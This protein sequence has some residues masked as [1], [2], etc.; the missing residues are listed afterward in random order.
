[1]SA[2]IIFFSIHTFF[3]LFFYQIQAGISATMHAHAK[4]FV[5]NI[6]RVPLYCSFARPDVTTNKSTIFDFFWFPT[7]AK[8]NVYNST[9]QNKINVDAIAHDLPPSFIANKS[10]REF[11]QEDWSSYIHYEQKVTGIESKQIEHLRFFDLYQYPGYREFVKTLPGY[12]QFIIEVDERQKIDNEFRKQL[13]HTFGWK[14]GEFT[15]YMQDEAEIARNTIAKEKQREA[16]ELQQ[17]QNEVANNEKAL[18]TERYAEYRH[19]KEEFSKHV[20]APE[21]KTQSIAEFGQHYFKSMANTA[22]ELNDKKA[23]IHYENRVQELKKIEL[24]KANKLFTLNEHAQKLVQDSKFDTQFLTI[25]KDGLEQ[26]VHSEIAN[27]INGIGT[28]FNKTCIEENRLK[29]IHLLSPTNRNRIDKIKELYNNAITLNKVALDLQQQGDS[30]G[31][32]LALDT[33]ADMTSLANSLL[34]D[35]NMTD[36]SFKNM[37]SK[38]ILWARF[39]KNTSKSNNK[40]N[41]VFWANN[42]SIGLAELALREKNTQAFLIRNKALFQSLGAIGNNAQAI[43]ELNKQCTKRTLITAIHLARLKPNVIY[44]NAGLLEGLEQAVTH[45]NYLRPYLIELQKQGIDLLNMSE[46]GNILLPKPTITKATTSFEY[47]GVTITLD[48]YGN[49]HTEDGRVRLSALGRKQLGWISDEALKDEGFQVNQLPKE[50][51]TG[52]RIIQT[53]DASIAE[54][55]RQH[56]QSLINKANQQHPVAQKTM[57]SNDVAKP[58]SHNEQFAQNQVEQLLQQRLAAV[59]ETIN[60]P[61]VL[62]TRTY[63]LTPVAQSF[64]QQHSCNL[65]SY[66]SFT[67]NPMQHQTHSEVI[68]VLNQNATADLLCSEL[69]HNGLTLSVLQYCQVAHALNQENKP[70]VALSFLDFCRVALSNALPID[71]ANQTLKDAI[72]IGRGLVRSGENALEMCRHPLETGK[73]IVK[74]FLI[75]MRHMPD[76]YGPDIPLIPAEN[77]P[78]IKQAEESTKFWKTLTDHIN[79]RMQNST[80]EERLEFVGEL[81]GDVITQH[82]A[83]KALGK[84]PQIATIVNQALAKPSKTLSNFGPMGK[85]LAR[86]LGTTL[87]HGPVKVEA[88]FNLLQEY[89][90]L[91]TAEGVRLQ[92]VDRGIECANNIQKFAQEA[93]EKSIQLLEHPELATQITKHQL[94][95]HYIPKPANIIPTV[96]VEGK[97]IYLDYTNSRWYQ[98]PNGKWYIEL[99]EELYQKIGWA[100]ENRQVLEATKFSTALENAAIVAQIQPG[101]V[102]KKLSQIAHTFTPAQQRFLA[103][104]EQEIDALVQKYAG[105]KIMVPGI[106]VPIEITRETI[107]HVL[108]A[109]I[110]SKVKKGYHLNLNGLHHNLSRW[111]QNGVIQ[112]SNKK[113]LPN[114]VTITGIEYRGVTLKDLTTAFPDIWSNEQ[115]FDKLIEACGNITQVPQIQSKGNWIFRGKTIEG[116]PFE[117]IVEKNGYIKTFYPPFKI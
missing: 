30:F 49:A 117:I 26:V 27:S 111:E 65:A 108:G 45:I 23:G 101:N 28:L 52:Y 98:A 40:F 66:E 44:R 1:M 62:T 105:K 56:Q 110:I 109:E 87:E 83:L 84:A 53:T 112:F 41:Q 113:T 16:R 86:M 46:D 102:T 50:V 72:A 100:F 67:G 68:Q 39:K 88:A 78:S 81:L 33:A 34:H 42:I 74:T 61:H 63:Q 43:V 114:G 21:A 8:V 104:V 48:K 55:I 89:P 15:R 18:I 20:I 91:V 4:Q 94:P 10:F 79:E 69:K 64:L 93:G 5:E 97:P 96:M 51:S 25:H 95:T 80:R 7:F 59:H 3:L 60:N 29:N 73:N 82:Y 57:P 76:T 107:E 37:L 12:Q 85:E 11:T 75:I 31:A 2:R 32:F 58:R 106:P 22:S 90:Q 70:E 6:P 99:S 115:L 103:A 38:Q 116:V 92:D 54:K 9:V 24:S 17:F 35:G 71:V 47:D 14:Y 13:D 19:K 36:M 77:D